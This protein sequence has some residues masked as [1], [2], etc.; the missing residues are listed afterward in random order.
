[1]VYKKLI[2]S[3]NQIEIFEYEKEPYTFRHPPKKNIVR[4]RRPRYKSRIHF[5]RADNSHRAKIRF[6][7]IVLSNLL[8][9]QNKCAFITF[10]FASYTTFDEGL[11][12]W[13]LFT[14]R[15]KRTVGCSLLY[16]M[17]PE[18]TQSGSI[19]FHALIFDLP[20]F[21][22]DDIQAGI[23]RG[24]VVSQ[25]DY[26][27]ANNRLLQNIWA[28]GYL[29]GISTDNNPAIAR[30]LSDYMHKSV[31]DYRFTGKRA[32]NIS[33]GL[34]RPLQTNIQSA[35]TFIQQDQDS[36]SLTL[37]YESTFNTSWLGQCIYRRYSTQKPII[38]NNQ[39]ETT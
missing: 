38:Q 31:Q 22:Y 35:I 5:K 20:S 1:M 2:Q 12:A 24:D 11:V 30:Y 9:T 3:G 6:N 39:K 21:F 29:D 7:R 15:Y 8:S 26:Q 13:N 23:K 16:I 18:F 37:K 32:Y 17:V 19:H 34:L 25:T 28:N 14:K 27:E 10:T 36:K 33:R 4:V